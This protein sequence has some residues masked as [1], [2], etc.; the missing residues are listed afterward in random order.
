MARQEKYLISAE[1]NV[2]F[3]IDIVLKDSRTGQ[4]IC[5]LDTKYKAETVPSPEDLAQVI[6]YATA[7]G[8]DDAILI[9]PAHGSGSF[10]HR[11]G[12]IRVRS[13]AFSLQDDLEAAGTVFARELLEGLRVA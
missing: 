2:H 8:C 12:H 5:V 13:I 3:R 9:Y 4:P 7:G 1:G 10:D 6:A 11:V